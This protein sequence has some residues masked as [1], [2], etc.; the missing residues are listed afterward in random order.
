M[1]FLSTAYRNLAPSD[2]FMTNGVFPQ[3]TL[4]DQI[5]LLNYKNL[6]SPKF[7]PLMSILNP[8]FIL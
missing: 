6:G 2:E 4:I 7:L 1:I 8:F 5:S 3:Y